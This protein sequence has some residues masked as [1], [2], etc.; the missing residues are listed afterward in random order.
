M[1][2]ADLEAATSRQELQERFRV[3]MDTLGPFR[4]CTSSDEAK[5]VYR[6]TVKRTHPDT[7]GSSEAQIA[8][9]NQY[10]TALDAIAARDRLHKL[11]ERYE[12][13][14]SPAT[15]TPTTQTAITPFVDHF[16]R[17]V[18]TKR[19]TKTI[20]KAA[21]DLAGELIRSGVGALLDKIGRR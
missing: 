21:G 16:K 6:T 4:C 9:D 2:V 14:V 7:G 15:P 20:S 19:A 18:S 11:L 10:R 13:V 12:V 3:L 5:K 17:R 1:T 8:L